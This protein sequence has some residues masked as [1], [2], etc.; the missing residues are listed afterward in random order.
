MK[1]CAFNGSPRGEAGN[2]NILVEEVLKGIQKEG[3]STENIILKDYEIKSCKGCF[4]CW[5][6]TPG[7]CIIDDD[8]KDLLPKFKE[9]EAVILA[10]PLY[11]DNI[12]AIL[13]LF[14]ERL[15]PLAEPFFE[16]DEKGES[17]HPKRYDKTPGL[18]VIS[19]SGFPEESHFQVL[20]LLFKRVARN[21]GTKVVGEIYRGA[22]ELLQVKNPMLEK[23]LE[24]YKELLQKAG[25]ELVK[26]GEVLDETEEELKK[27]LVPHEE[28]I[29]MA[30][31]YWNKKVN[32]TD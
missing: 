12:T 25:S 11:V 29:K 20:E 28:Y 24:S 13:K 26:N 31:K 15:I 16:K 17:V 2:T 21:F 23:Q 8:M 27:P 5:T 19:N 1:F 7:E 3:G 10:S 32:G 6:K 9:S 18:V 22:G 30:N 14:M 4:S